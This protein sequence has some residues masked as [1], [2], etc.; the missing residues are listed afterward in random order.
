MV[1]L[2]LL[3]MIHPKFRALK[4]FSHLHLHSHGDGL[5]SKHSHSNGEGD[6][7][8]THKKHHFGRKPKHAV[9]SGL[10]IKKHLKPLTFKF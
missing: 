8:V 7:I 6:G 4:H 9:Q 1:N 10:S 3:S 2:H 5:Y